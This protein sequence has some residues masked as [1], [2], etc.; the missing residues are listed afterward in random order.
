[1]VYQCHPGGPDDYVVVYIGGEAWDSLLAI[2]GRSETI[3]DERYSTREARWEHAEEVEAMVSEWTSSRT[4]REVMEALNETG[5]PGGAVLSTAN[6]LEDP[7]FA[8]G[9]WSL[10]S[11]TRTGAN[12]WRWDVRSN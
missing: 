2:M 11:M 1:M 10:K 8:R 12:T 9:R 6:V 7:T 4:K 3:G 5:V